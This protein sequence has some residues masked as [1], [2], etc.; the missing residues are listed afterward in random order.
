MASIDLRMQQT[1]LQAR[2]SP[3][4]QNYIAKSKMEDL[5]IGKPGEVFESA[6]AADMVEVRKVK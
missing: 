4:F 2:A 3:E 5:S 6:F 1:L